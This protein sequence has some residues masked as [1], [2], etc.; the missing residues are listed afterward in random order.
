MYFVIVAKTIKGMC[1]G[2]FSGVDILISLKDVDKLIIIDALQGNE[3]PG[4]VYRLH[5]DDLPA[6]SDSYMSLHH[7]NILEGLN[8]ARKTGNAPHEAVIIGIEPEDIDWGLGVTSHI[9]QK[10]PEIIDIV[11]EEVKHDCY[12]EETNN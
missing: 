1:L 3:K 4:T 7:M 10:F 9:Q 12:R 2:M 8:I 6:P 5:P 11:L